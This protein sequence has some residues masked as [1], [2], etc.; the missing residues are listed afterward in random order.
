MTTLPKTVYRQID[1]EK[2]EIPSSVRRLERKSALISLS[3]S[4]RRFGVL[5]PIGICQNGEKYSL[6]YGSRRL[7]AARL[8]G[9]KTI[10]CLVSDAD[11]AEAD[12][13]SLH[14][15]IHRKDLHYF[16]LSDAFVRTIRGKRYTVSRLSAQLCVGEN[17][18]RNKCILSVLPLSAR[19]EM[20]RRHVP[21]RKALSFCSLSDD[22]SPVFPGFTQAHE[23]GYCRDLRLYLNS[24]RHTIDKMEQAGLNATYEKEE[25]DDTV[26]WRI[27][28]QKA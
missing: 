16:E 10:P 28:I 15:N 26:I 7:Y 17:E 9:L 21:E 1:I 22:G 12:I 5:E 2:I 19:K 3:N 4:I 25:T 27:L 24:I 20:I 6:L 18:I 8:A 23:K 11:G 14:E 13:L